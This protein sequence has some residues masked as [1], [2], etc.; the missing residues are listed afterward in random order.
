MN[1]FHRV[2]ISKNHE[3]NLLNLIISDLICNLIRKT[4]LQF[5]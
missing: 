4:Y 3:S 1:F 5:Q 2:I